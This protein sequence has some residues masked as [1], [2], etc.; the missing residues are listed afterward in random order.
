MLSC[1]GLTKRYGNHIVLNELDFCAERGQIVGI[2][3]ANG[4]GKTTMFEVLSG[5]QRADAGSIRMAG[6]EIARLPAHARSR[7]GLGRTFQSP[8]VPGALTVDE[9]LRAATRAYRPEP[10]VDVGTATRLVELEVD[11]A[12]PSADL[13]ALARR[14]L[15]LG[16][17]LMRA[18][19]VLLLD[20]PC[21]GLL[22]EEIREIEKIV[23]RIVEVLGTAVVVIEH[24]LELLY[25]VADIVHVLHGGKWIA[26]GDPAYAFAEPSVRDVYFGDVGGPA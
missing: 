15:L 16:C 3:G 14:R 5:G 11:P 22:D 24:R 2:A 1:V 7:L 18:P 6:K 26:S 21:S 10:A 13:D 4:A 25:A 8:I 12:T 19:R 20:E 17:L 23:A 9:V